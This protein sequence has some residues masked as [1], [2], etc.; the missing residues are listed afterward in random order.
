M[1]A[2]ATYILRG[3]VV[4]LLASLG[5]AK[6]ANEPVTVKQA[7]RNAFDIALLL[8]QYK[9][10]PAK[11][12]ALKAK[13]AEA[14]PEGAND[15]TLAEFYLKRSQVATELGNG[16]LSFEDIKRAKSLANPYSTLNWWIRLELSSRHR[17]MGNFSQ[18]VELEQEAIQAANGSAGAQIHGYVNLI[19]L[20]LNIGDFQMAKDNLAKLETAFQVVR[21]QQRDFMTYG[22][23]YE[24][25]LEQGRGIFLLATGKYGEAE[26][27]L[28]QAIKSLDSYVS[29][30]QRNPKLSPLSSASYMMRREGMQLALATAQRE[31]GKFFD[32]EFTLRE[33][34]R[35]GLTV[36]GA[37]DPFTQI[38]VISVASF[39][40]HLGRYSESE[41]ILQRVLQL[42]S[43]IGVDPE[44]QI[45]IGARLV[46]GESLTGQQ[47][48][49]EALATWQSA[50][51]DVSADTQR[52]VRLQRHSI[53]QVVAR[54][55]NGQ[56]REGLALAESKIEE[57][58][59]RL[60]A[61]HRE[62]LELL[63]L[64]AVAWGKLGDEQKAIAAFREYVPA[65]LQLNAEMGDYSALAQQRLALIVETYMVL[66]ARQK[67]RV[68]GPITEQF[69]AAEVFQLADSM[70]SGTT[71]QAVLA[72]AIRALAKD[73]AIGADIRKLQDLDQ[74][75]ASLQRIL[76]DL[77]NAPVEQSLPKVVA[78]MKERIKTIG[79]E[80]KVQ[81]AHIE[82][83]FPA[84][85]HL[86]S[87]RPGNLNEARAVLRDGE[88]LVSIF[89]T[90]LESYVWAMKKDGTTAFSVVPLTREQIAGKVAKLRSALDPGDVD[91]EHALPR[92]DFDTGFELYSKLLVPVATGWQGATSLLVAASGALGQL[93]LAVLPM[94]KVSADLTAPTASKGIPYTDY[95]DVPWL[96]RQMA[97]T[98]LPS[99]NALMVLRKLPAGSA[100]RTP[101]IGFGDPMFG[102]EQIAANRTR[103]LR[104][105]SIARAEPGTTILAA[106]P[107]TETKPAAAN[108][109]EWV[110]YSKIPP[111]PDTRE[112]ILSLATTLKA[113]TTKDVFLGAD[114]SKANVKKLDLSRRRIVAFATHGLLPNDFPGVNEP[115]L[116]LANPQD[117][118]HGLLTLEDILGLKL[119]ADWVVLSACNTAAGDGTA[120]DAVSGLGRGFFYA[121]TRA[122]LVTHWP[123]ES[124]SARLL[125]TGLFE[126][127]AANVKLSRAEALR[128]SMLALMQQRS[129]SENFAYAHPLFWAPYALVGDGAN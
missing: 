4:L 61:G 96:I 71:Q 128:Q 18:A 87:P 27:R 8:E 112:E 78:D 123:V 120:A 31:Q 13:V 45:A 127:Q 39:L 22:D 46:L 55:Q 15:Q 89:S 109:P 64:Q 40:N 3:I 47:K 99:V 73:P 91:I 26:M 74:E 92:F 122:L 129:K 68:D 48:W 44:S 6:G 84:Y 70:R 103:K 126:R 102:K 36:R 110:D 56:A 98:Q 124:V 65:I 38:I 113:D 7:P 52:A 79:E 125:V 50:I 58:R 35:S 5:V 43:E 75:Q 24:S 121:G 59:N 111:L 37:H 34:L 17:L 81:R 10:D 101:F 105:L 72:S 118:T 20:A 83:N 67:H 12:E 30:M 104:N 57:S 115:S 106:T 117:G 28:Q 97:V 9:P 77:M 90:S 86:V 108:A 80:R 14:P 32:A 51:S 54:I 25:R 41:T 23:T 116:A 76:R 114:A 69:A 33:A 85:T 19:S 107:A 100:E 1:P 60:G 119:D 66:L 82:K 11:I 49:K 95:A 42:L 63:A 16:K 29:A 93:P 21:G 62:V 2:F 53:S 88:A 94:Q